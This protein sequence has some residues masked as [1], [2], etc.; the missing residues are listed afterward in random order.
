MVV[1]M[2]QD[3]VKLYPYQRLPTAASIRLVRVLPGRV[4]GSI[5]C[6]LQTVNSPHHTGVEYQA[7]SY[8]WGDPK[9]TQKI[10][11]RDENDDFLHEH[12]LH[13]N[14]WQFLDKWQQPRTQPSGLMWTDSLCL[15]QSDSEE[16]GQQIRRMGEIYSGAT[17]V[18]V[19]LGPDTASMA[20]TRDRKAE[21]SQ[22]AATRILELPYWRRAW[23]VQELALAQRALVTC[24]DISMEL[25]EFRDTLPTP[26]TTGIIDQLCGLHRDK[27]KPLWWILDRLA[28]TAESTRAVDI[29]FGF[30][31]L[32]LPS[33]NGSSPIDYIKVDYARRPVD[34]LFDAVFEA[35][36][37]FHDTR[38]ILQ[39]LETSF[40]RAQEAH[41]IRADEEA[42][43]AY[44]REREISE[45]HVQLASLALRVSEAVKV[46]V[47]QL[48]ISSE[49]WLKITE[50]ISFEF[51]R[52]AK[53]LT[54][55]Q[56][57]PSQHA[58]FV[59]FNL[60]L[61]CEPLHENVKTKDLQRLASPWLCCAHR[62]SK[63]KPGEENCRYP[64]GAKMFAFDSTNVARLCAKYSL[65][66]GCDVSRVDFNVSEIGFRMTLS[67]HRDINR[68]SGIL[69]VEFYAD[70]DEWRYKAN[71]GGIA[72]WESGDPFLGI[73]YSH[74]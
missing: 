14:L 71:K 69:G 4:D 63:E 30:F 50:G 3:R 66:S 5:V 27:G 44:L 12:H 49:I 7:L 8:L 11:V 24:G 35:C 1:A 65:E 23:I 26:R 18:I 21:G 40:G 6:S 16:K 28:R 72:P 54:S 36:P 47:T 42:L 31:G 67:P 57:S 15:N 37:P 52:I 10:Y 60:T 53:R 19:W 56:F 41:D 45:R 51:F 13:E 74:P 43:G 39:D 29:V 9:P 33:E 32:V 62:K 48:A 55:A 68:K 20:W 25:N 2:M 46:V 59:G 61:N 70:M 17:E 34:V 73:R 64:R 58:A 38:N 22:D